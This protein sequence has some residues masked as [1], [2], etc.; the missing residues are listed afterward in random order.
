MVRGG[1][2]TEHQ[3]ARA[4]CVAHRVVVGQFEI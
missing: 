1:V 3:I 4:D 2:D